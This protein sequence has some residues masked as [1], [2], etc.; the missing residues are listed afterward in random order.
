MIWS[1]I[2]AVSRNLTIAFVSAVHTCASTTI[3]GCV[4]VFQSYLAS[5][6][7]RTRMRAR[8]ILQTRMIRTIRI[9]LARPTTWQNQTNPMM[10]RA[11]PATVMAMEANTLRSA[12][13][14]RHKSC[15]DNSIV[16]RGGRQAHT[17]TCCAH[18][19]PCAVAIDSTR[20]YATLII[21]S[22]RAS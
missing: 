9:R 7:P 20:A 5:A 11:F 6:L 22:W 18:L 14:S 8:A 2:S 15:S 16:I 4:V 13:G 17:Y 12:Q 1:S 10:K 3:Y 21:T 19:T